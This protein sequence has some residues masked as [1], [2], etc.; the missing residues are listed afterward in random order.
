MRSNFKMDSNSISVLMANY[1]HEKYIKGAIES[2][3][4]QS[5]DNWELIIVD[6]GSTDNSLEKIKPF[7]KDKRIKLIKHDKNLGYGGSLK[8][9]AE[10]ASKDILGI[11]DPDDKLHKNAIEA[12]ADSY[13][14]NPNCGFI[15]SKMWICDANLKNCIIDNNIKS[16]IPPQTNLFYSRISHFK[17]FLKSAYN[18]TPGFD[19]KQK[20]SVDKDI[21]Y[22]LEEVTEFKFINIPLYYYRQYGGGISQGKNQELA[23]LYHLYAKFKAYKR[24]LGTNIP[25]YTKKTLIL[26]YYKLIKLHKLLQILRIL[27]K[28]LKINILF[29]NLIRKISVK[30][31]RYKLKRVYLKVASFFKT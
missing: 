3:I 17:T 20:K 21:I 14:K 28:F 29:S 27:I 6:D 10:Y 8:T 2:M 12:I 15:Y 23:L 1:N 26:E 11:L 19:P 22:K 30:S 31:L 4:N 24:R 18:K 5:N 7:L 16:I 9:A 25:N 13:N